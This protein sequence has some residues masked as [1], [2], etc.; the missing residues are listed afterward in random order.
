MQ[1]QG[2]DQKLQGNCADI[3]DV[4]KVLHRAI[5]LRLENEKE[6]ESWKR[7]QVG[8]IEG[9]SCQQ[10]QVMMT[11]LLQKHWSGRKKEEQC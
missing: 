9:T 8:G 11:K 6:L 10:F 7:L 2:R 3:S 5:V 4:E 1:S